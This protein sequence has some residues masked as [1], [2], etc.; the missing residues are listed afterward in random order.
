M[1]VY[2]MKGSQGIDRVLV[3]FE[4]IHH[5]ELYIYLQLHLITLDSVQKDKLNYI[6]DWMSLGVMHSACAV[7]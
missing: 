5:M 3:L 1:R 7:S 2:E 4:K 6:Q